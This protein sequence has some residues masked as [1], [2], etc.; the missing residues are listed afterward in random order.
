MGCSAKRLDSI[1]G[2]IKSMR[3]VDG[4]RRRGVAAGILTHIVETAEQEG[5]RRLSLETRS[6]IL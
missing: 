4:F 5:Y 2:E 1:H 3:T 6:R